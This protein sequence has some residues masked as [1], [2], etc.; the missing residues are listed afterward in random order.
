[1]F[2][3]ST[4]RY[5]FYLHT[6]ENFLHNDQWLVRRSWRL[7][8]LRRNLDA[9][10]SF[11]NKNKEHVWVRTVKDTSENWTRNQEIGCGIILFRFKNIREIRTRNAPG[12]YTPSHIKMTYVMLRCLQREWGIRTPARTST[13]GYLDNKAATARDPKCEKTDHTGWKTE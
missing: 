5:I 1:M 11:K 2:R 4:E 13:C 7:G 10:L 8:I 9:T 12:K 6:K 3:N